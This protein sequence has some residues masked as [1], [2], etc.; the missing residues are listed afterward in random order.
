MPSIT[1]LGVTSQLRNWL[2]GVKTRPLSFYHCLFLYN[3]GALLS[4]PTTPHPNTFL[5]FRPT[6]PL[7]FLFLGTHVGVGPCGGPF[8]PTSWTLWAPAFLG[9]G[10]E[11][12]TL[13]DT[14]GHGSWEKVST[15]K[16]PPPGIRG[17]LQSQ[18]T[19]EK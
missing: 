17:P 2:A 4:P 14:Q 8:G 5:L 6:H 11:L 7:L 10:S 3:F 1:R 12:G 18:V 15:N 13:G 9:L 16:L 19:G